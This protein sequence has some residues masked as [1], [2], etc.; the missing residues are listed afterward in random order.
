MD[1]AAVRVV[2]AE[3]GTGA[4]SSAIGVTPFHVGS[5]DP[6]LTALGFALADLLTTDLA[7]S[8][9]VRLVERGRLG[10]VLKEFDLAAAGI[11]DSAT[12][13]RVGRM[14]QAGQLLL[15]SIDSLPDG[16]FRLSVRIADVAT[17]VLATALD[18]RAPIAEILTAEKAIAF[19]L[20]DALGVTLS[21]AERQLVEAQPTRSLAALIDYGRGVAAEISGDWRSAFEAY[22]R[23]SSVDPGFR[24]AA[25]RATR[26]QANLTT[27]ASSTALLP[28]IRG[29]DAPVTSV[30][31]RLNRPIDHITS[32]TRP[33]GGVGDPA[34]PGTMVTVVITI[35]RP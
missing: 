33:L 25:D 24:G 7:R 20:F 18:A 27:V 14:L 1:T 31:D 34:F 15:G 11:V 23:A 3:R 12:A 30:V 28:G 21:P 32:Q 13:P 26:A 5:R 16:Q 17:S 19:R 29:V 4:S 6:S 2:A 35:R 8:S 10:E 22:R 9:Q